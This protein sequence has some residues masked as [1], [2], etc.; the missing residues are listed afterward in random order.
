M[1]P[2][3]AH[4]PPAGDGAQCDVGT[5]ML[6]DSREWPFTG[7][8]AGIQGIGAVGASAQTG[9]AN[10]VSRFSAAATEVA[11]SSVGAGDDS[12][13]FSGAARAQLA[14]SQGSLEHGLTEQDAAQHDLAANVRV[15]QTADEMFG[16]LTSI[17][18]KT[19]P[20]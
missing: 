1:L 2:K 14:Q 6:E 20:R 4:P 13:S 10:A 7:T 11:T 8:M 16:T 3:A 18:S 17:G 5:V 12:A 19:G 9:I 15:L